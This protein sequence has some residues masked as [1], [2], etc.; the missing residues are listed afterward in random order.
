MEGYIVSVEW[1]VYIK[2]PVIRGQVAS[3]NIAHD[4]LLSYTWS[5]GSLFRPQSGEASFKPLLGS[6]LFTQVLS[7]WLRCPQA[8]AWILPGLDHGHFLEY[9]QWSYCS[10]QWHWSPIIFPKLV[11]DLVTG[12]QNTSFCQKNGIQSERTILLVW[13][14]T[15]RTRP[16][17]DS[18]VGMPLSLLAKLLPNLITRIQNAAFFQENGA[19]PRNP[20]I[21]FNI[22]YSWGP[23]T[24]RSLQELYLRRWFNALRCHSKCPF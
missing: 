19:S 24:P 13:G 15:W 7:C 6:R 12:I 22:L 8:N 1:R 17:R 18:I 3:I 11:P 10:M 4:W 16:P 14:R 2:G 5:C 20:T 21:N 23:P 9:H